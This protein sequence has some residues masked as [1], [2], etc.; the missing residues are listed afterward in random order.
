[1]ELLLSA[2][3]ALLFIF[4]IYRTR[5]FHVQGLT[6]ARITAVFLLKI[7]CGVGM[8]LIYT[9]YYTDR[10]TADVFKYYD[11][12]RIMYEALHSNPGDF[13]RML[14]GFRDDTE[15]FRDTYYTHMANWYRD[16]ESTFNDSRTIIRVNAFLR[17]FSFGYFHV[18]TVFMCFISLIGLACIYRLFASYMENKRVEL[19]IAVFLLPS[20]LFWGSGVLKEGIMLF[21]LGV[22]VYS[23]H[24]ILT[25]D[26][27]VKRMVLVLIGFCTLMITKYYILASLLVGL[28]ANL[29]IYRTG[30]KRPVLKYLIVAASIGIAGWIF[31]QA[32]PA[33]NPLLILSQK[34]KNF[35]NLARG[36]AYVANDSILV[37]LPI[38][39]RAQL[40]PTEKDSVLTIKKGTPIVYWDLD[41][42]K[43]T[44]YGVSATDTARYL[45]WWDMV[46]SGSRIELPPL[47]PTLASFLLS[48]PHA[49]VNTLL[50]P[51]PLEA[52]SPFMLM[53]AAENLLFLA[54]LLLCIFFFQ[55]PSSVPMFCLCIS[56]VLVLYTLSGL[57]TPVLGALVRYKMPAMPFLA[58]A[59]LMLINKEKLMNRLRFKR[60][61]N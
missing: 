15:Y 46:P 40:V 38:E 37:Y 21:G 50:R 56:F 32:K 6:P 24:R 57:V 36:G 28:A 26:M 44:L 61:K 59:L 22:L 55:R 51:H 27:T 41:N 14:T 5:F 35:I 18:H 1:M 39:H 34:Q 49:L 52:R 13:F 2:A 47:Q 20:V 8:A 3:Y 9:Y 7:M 54:L 10:T 42:V 12:S 31:A 30:M 60:P 29:W 16:F 45:L 53:A 25:G 19:F 33:Y 11:D 58:I 48:T 4:V 23:F 17:I 43:D